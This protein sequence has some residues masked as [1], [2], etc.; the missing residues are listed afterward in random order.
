MRRCRARRHASNRDIAA[1]IL[2]P[3]GSSF[4]QQ[5][6]G[7]EFVQELRRLTEQHRVLLILD[8]VVTGFRVSSGGAQAAFGV[9]PDLSSFAKIVAG[10]LPGAAV[11]GRQDIL[12]QLDFAVSQRT[13]R[14]KIQHP[15]TFN[16]NPV[17]AA[18]GTAALTVIAETDACE[19][20][21]RTAATLRAALNA[22]LEDEG[23]VGGH[24]TYSVSHI[25]QSTAEKI[26]PSSFDAKKLTL[27]DL[28]RH[29]EGVVNKPAGALVQR[30]REHS[31]IGGF[32]SATH[33]SR[34]GAPPTRVSATPC[35]VRQEGERRT[36]E[37]QERVGFCSQA[38]AGT[39]LLALNIFGYP[40]SGR[41]AERRL[42]PGH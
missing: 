21:S 23:G 5:P 8:E 4:G 22:V 28:K 13:G 31:R 17:S 15:G 1:V 26:R 6:I 30:G 16:A 38:F 25:P 24:G 20:A 19:R 14:E 12:D 10:G 40:A 32:L 18:A 9:R 34:C 39:L 27:D 37:R 29:I 41:A 35:M 3:T 36:E 7:A 11:A 42:G 2:E 33:A